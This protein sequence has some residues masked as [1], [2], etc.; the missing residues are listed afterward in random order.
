MLFLPVPT[1]IGF[2]DAEIIEYSRSSHSLVVCVK[3]W[4]EE[5]LLVHFEGP[6]AIYDRG[7]WSVSDL[8]EVKAETPLLQE[9][10]AHEYDEIPKDHGL[11]QFQFLDVDGEPTLEIVAR[12]VKIDRRAV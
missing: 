12:G 6:A 1:D 3:A 2:A 7:I 5:H 8:R 4:N 10:L 11:R 9:A